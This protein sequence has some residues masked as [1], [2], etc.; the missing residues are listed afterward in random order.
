MTDA[1]AATDNF[2][3]LVSATILLVTL[4]NKIPAIAKWYRSHDLAISLAVGYRQGHLDNLTDKGKALLREAF[5][6]L[7][8]AL[9]QT[10]E[11]LIDLALSGTLGDENLGN[12]SLAGRSSVIQKTHM[13][14]PA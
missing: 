4:N 13:S 10:P 3:Q 7:A 5:F 6:V 8:N 1:D 11:E 14:E 12:E 9:E 2:E